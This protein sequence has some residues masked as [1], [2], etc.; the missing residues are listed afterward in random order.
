[1][2][3]AKKIEVPMKICVLC[4]MDEE[5]RNQLFFNC[6][7]WQDYTSTNWQLVIEELL[8]WAKGKTVVGRVGKALLAVVVYCL[9]HYRNGRIFRYTFKVRRLFLGILEDTLGLKF[10]NGG[11]V[12]LIAIG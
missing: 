7:F 3:I 6:D 12:E 11:R 5:T 2:K 8:K 9:W 10:V 1:M 4:G